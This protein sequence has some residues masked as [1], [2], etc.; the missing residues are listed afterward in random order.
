MAKDGR[1]HTKKCAAAALAVAALVA[2]AACGPAP[3]AF[4]LGALVCWAC[5]RLATKKRGDLVP[6]STPAA[7]PAK[8]QAMPAAKPETQD[9]GAQP[10]APASSSPAD[11]AAVPDTE[12]APAPAA[13]E[14]D[15]HEEL[16][17]LVLR[18]SDVIASLADLVRHGDAPAD[19]RA[20][21]ERSG[22]LG[23]SGAPRVEA[24][25]LQRSGHWWLYAADELPDADYDRM[26][27]AE[28]LLNLTDD[29]HYQASSVNGSAPADVAALDDRIARILGAVDGLDPFGAPDESTT[30]LA[31]GAEEG[32]E[33]AA[34]LA[35]ADFAESLPAPLRV[36]VSFQVNIADGLTVVD[37]EVPRPQ[38]FVSVASDEAGRAAWSRSYAMRLCLALG[39]GAFGAS[40]RIERVVV[41]GHEHGTRTPVISIDLTRS[42]LDRLR[43]ELRA[44]LVGELPQGL[45]IRWYATADGRLAPVD[46]IMTVWDDAVAPLSRWEGVEEN[47]L[48]APDAV[49]VATK[50]RAV[51]D[52]G[53]NEKFVRIEA[54][55]EAAGWLGASTRRAVAAFEA[56]RQKATDR[57]VAEA[58]ERVSRALVDGDID[59]FDRQSMAL[60][61]VEGG[62]LATTVRDAA[63][64]INGKPG[65]TAEEVEDVLARLDAALEPASQTARYEDDTEN[66][67]RY[68][69][70]TAERVRY[71]LEADDNGRELQLVPDEY[72][73]AHAQAAQLLVALGRHEE[74]LA[75]A[76]EDVRI[77]PYTTDA[78]LTEVRCLEELSRVHEAVDVLELAIERASNVREMS[79]CFYR[80]AFMEWKLGR[81][82]TSVACYQRAMELH[83]CVRDRAARE[84]A[85]VL[86][87][88][89]RLGKLSR[90]EARETI[91][92]EGIPYG[93]VEG[94]RTMMRDAAVACADAG[95]LSAARPL[96]GVLLEAGNDDA[97]LDVYTSLVPTRP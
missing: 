71:N 80:L 95:L 2:A 82:R 73:A 79:I 55:N 47:H 33:W 76:R 12:E 70:S 7:S 69:N 25:M 32:G 29:L 14:R 16:D 1:Q 18:S 90:E 50:S 39:R 27:A 61:F 56:R 45:G 46:P 36:A 66:V 23:W 11:G 59:V 5:Q 64:R 41:N 78:A 3:F 49:A 88:E 53:I 84:L 96:A 24:K 35:I 72:Y 40:G 77:A 54:W 85:D 94:L 15:P 43:D 87:A 8:G 26:L 44:L 60:L 6:L 48:P 81:G 74:A 9:E 93:D 20:L 65:H 4:V 97:L 10:A 19:L 57:T 89:K 91:V 42:G 21:V 92:A 52:L 37:V 51:S 22:L 17:D 58:C 75:H 38:V 67:F 86:A 83:E 13:P 31:Q 63:L 34:R 68:F 30:F 28:L 62:E